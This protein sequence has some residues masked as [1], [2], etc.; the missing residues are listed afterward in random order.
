MP[1]PAPGRASCTQG[2]Y[3]RSR[4]CEPRMR[5]GA[6]CGRSAAAAARARLR[7]SS[8]ARCT[9]CPAAT[10]APTCCTMLPP[11]APSTRTHTHTHSL[12]HTH[13][14]TRS[15]THTHSLTHTRRAPNRLPLPRTAPPLSIP[16]ASGRPVRRLT[17][18]R[19]IGESM[20]CVRCGDYSGRMAQVR[21]GSGPQAGAVEA[22]LGRQVAACTRARHAYGT[23]DACG[24]GQEA[25][26]P[27]LASPYLA[28]PRLA[29]PYLA[30]PRL[31]LSCPASPRCLPR[32]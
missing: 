11:L 25:A 29:S 16:R 18:A 7:W 8:S 4:R 32:P 19:S 5:V 15:L 2:V 3:V 24:G 31:A 6:V 30:S 14:L 20:R 10:T 28:L 26:R 27:R 9:A 22:V 12:T 1:P 21:S 13:T 17:H 23:G